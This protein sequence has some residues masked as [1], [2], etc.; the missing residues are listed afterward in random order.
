MGRVSRRRR[1]RRR[2]R[3]EHFSADNTFSRERTSLEVPLALRR[4]FHKQP[5]Y[6]STVVI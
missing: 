5:F 3:L 1:R 4:L 2:R 6:E